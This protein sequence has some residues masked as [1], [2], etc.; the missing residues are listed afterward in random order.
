MRDINLKVRDGI[1]ILGV[2][3]VIDG[4]LYAEYDECDFKEENSTNSKC[5]KAIAQT[6]LNALELTIK[7][8]LRVSKI[9]Y[10]KKE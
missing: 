3:A 5:R 6:L 9:Q 1:D 8:G 4:K 7:S 10:V 2:F